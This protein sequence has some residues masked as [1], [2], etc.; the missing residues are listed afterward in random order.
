MLLF[1]EN[2]EKKVIHI[3]FCLIARQPSYHVIDHQLS[4][5]RAYVHV[6]IIDE[7]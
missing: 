3:E 7:Q 4:F 5:L 1:L 2:N 6:A